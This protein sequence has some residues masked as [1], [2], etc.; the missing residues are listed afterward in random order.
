M[1]REFLIL[2]NLRGHAEERQIKRQQ[3]GQSEN[4]CRQTAPVSLNIIGNRHDCTAQHEE[5]KKD[6]RE[7]EPDISELHD[8]LQ[9]PICFYC[10]FQRMV[11]LRFA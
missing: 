7:I 10:H 3:K 6:A 5:G 4:K 1:S 8:S 11:G 9:F 2:S